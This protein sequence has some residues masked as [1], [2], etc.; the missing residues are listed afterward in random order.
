M[1]TGIKE[2]IAGNY[3][4][5]EDITSESKIELKNTYIQLPVKSDGTPDYDYMSTFI[6]AM[7]KVVIKDVVDYLDKRIDKTKQLFV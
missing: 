2:N 4:K 3:N 7:Q 1:L 5:K 6:S